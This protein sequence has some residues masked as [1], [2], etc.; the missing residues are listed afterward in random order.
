LSLLNAQ[1]ERLSSRMKAIIHYYQNQV[2]CRSKQLVAYFGDHSASDC[3]SCDVCLARKKRRLNEDKQVLIRQHL[4]DHLSKESLSLENLHK[5]SAFPTSEL[6]EVLR[7]MC[8]NDEIEIQ[9]DNE[10]I[11][12][13]V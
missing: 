11:L 4:I 13:A 1:K 7:W 6:I 10:L 2:I 3:G 9:D 5:L 12:K 8:D